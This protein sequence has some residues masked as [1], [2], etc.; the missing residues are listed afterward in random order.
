MLYFVTGR[1]GSGKTSF[2]RNKLA[3]LAKS[4]KDGMILIVPEQFSFES[5]RSM[6]SMLGA[7]DAL[8]I[9]ILSF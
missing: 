7:K 9:E 2:V 6:L 8:N 1:A 4:G 5:E 3:Q